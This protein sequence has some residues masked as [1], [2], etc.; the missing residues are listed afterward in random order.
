M[1]KLILDNLYENGVINSPDEKDVVSPLVKRYLNNVS[2]YTE[3]VKL[4]L[5]ETKYLLLNSEFDESSEK[6]KFFKSNTNCCTSLLIPLT[7]FLDEL[8]FSVFRL[9]QLI[10]VSLTLELL[11]PI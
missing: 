10:V 2:D 7:L 11:A 3:L 1:R 4:E 6:F 5:L 8:I 9:S